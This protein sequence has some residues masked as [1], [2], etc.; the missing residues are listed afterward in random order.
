V[1]IIREVIHEGSRIKHRSTWFR[2]RNGPI[3]ILMPPAIF[4]HRHVSHTVKG[5]DSS[6]AVLQRSRGLL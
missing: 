4:P 5:E 3:H 1:E 2:F 6:M